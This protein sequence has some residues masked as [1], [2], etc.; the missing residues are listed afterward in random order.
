[1]SD[2][3]GVSN[4]T[5]I[6]MKHTSKIVPDCH[7]SNNNTVQEFESLKRQASGVKVINSNKAQKL[8]QQF[9]LKKQEG[10]LGNTGITIHPHVQKGFYV[11]KK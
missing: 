5:S 1:M 9:N 8:R 6:D 2:T 10:V 11:L 3:V 7:K 4:A